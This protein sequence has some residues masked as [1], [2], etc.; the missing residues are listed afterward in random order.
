VLFN[1]P[2]TGIRRSENTI[3]DT[4]RTNKETVMKGIPPL[5]TLAVTGSGDVSVPSGDYE[6]KSFLEIYVLLY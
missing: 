4:N 5:Q 2:I 3:H 1:N 6:P